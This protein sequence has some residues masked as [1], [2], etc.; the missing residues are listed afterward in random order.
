MCILPLCAYNFRRANSTREEQS[1]FVV[2]NAG[3]RRF[4]AFGSLSYYN[5]LLF[6]V[7]SIAVL[8]TLSEV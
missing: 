4:L 2:L 6:V 7:V 5:C 1:C 3:S 8:D